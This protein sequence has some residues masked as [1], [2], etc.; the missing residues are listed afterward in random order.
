MADPRR[1]TNSQKKRANDLDRRRLES[2]DLLKK[3]TPAQL[4]DVIMRGEMKA[5]ADGFSAGGGDGEIRGGSENTTVESAALYGLPSGKPTDTLGNPIEPKP[6][7]WAKHHPKDPIG[8][9]IAEA[10]TSL[11]E[12]QGNAKRAANL[13]AYVLDVRGEPTFTYCQG[14]HRIVE[15]GRAD[16]IRGGYCSACDPAWRR[17]KA[18]QG[19]D[20]NGADRHAF[21]I[22][23][24][25][26]DGHL[27]TAC[28]VCAEQDQ[29]KRAS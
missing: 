2:I 23:R 1:A 12:A 7:D 17:F 6:D 3:I 21:E 28:P 29:L 27:A 8:D 15:G 10:I 9:A 22:E 26:F 14:C 25:R 16:P 4:L 19:T 24:P 13:V 20:D 18:T 11:H 5:A